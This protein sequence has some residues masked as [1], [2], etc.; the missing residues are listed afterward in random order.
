MSSED[1]SLSKNP[2]IAFFGNVKQ[3]EEYIKASRINVLTDSSF[4]NLDEK[5]NVEK[6]N[7]K[8]IVEK[9]T[10]TVV[11]DITNE[12]LNDYLQR[13]F[14]ITLSSD[15]SNTGI[16]QY[17]GLPKRC[18]KLEELK[19]D[20][21]SSNQPCQ[22][23]EFNLNQALMERLQM[24]EAKN[25]VCVQGNYHEKASAAVAEASED[26]LIKYLSHCYKRLVSEEA[27]LLR[28]NKDSLLAEKVLNLSKSC[29]RFIVSFT[30]TI[31]LQPDIFPTNNPHVQLFNIIM[32]LSADPDMNEFLCKLVE[33]HTDENDL[34]EIFRPLLDEIWERCVNLKLLHKDVSALLESI[35]FFSKYNSLTWILL[36]SP[37]WLPRFSSHLV[38]L[39]VAFS[40]QTLLGR[41]LQLSP[42]PNDVTTPSEHFL[43]PSRQSESQM[44]FITESLQRQT[45]FI[46][47]KLH[48][49]LYNIMKVPDAQHRVMYWIGLCLDCNKDR[50]KM[51]VDSSVVAPA[52]FFVNL[53]HV[54]LKFCQPFLVPNS[55]LL[56]KVDCRYGAIKTDHN[57]IRNKDTPIHCVGLSAA[58]PMAHKSDNIPSIETD[59][60][61]FK[62]TADIFFLTHQCY[63]LGFIKVYEEYHELMKQLQKTSNTIRDLGI[64]GG[65]DSAMEEIKNKFEFGMRLQLSMKAALCNSSL[66]DLSIQF[67]AASSFWLIQ[68]V[69]AGKDYLKMEQRELKAKY[70]T[71][72]VPP[73]LT[74]IPEFLAE[75]IGDTMRMMGYFNEETLER[76]ANLRYIM[77]FFA[78]FL[79]SSARIK[80]PHLRAK[81]AESLAVFLPKETEQHNSLFSYSFRKKAFLESSVVPK[82]L[83]KSLLQLFVDIEFTGHTMEF[84]QKFNYRH[85]MYG[86]LEYIWNIPSYHTEFKKLD[87]EGKIQYKRDM[88]F[89]SFPRFINLLINDSTYLLDEALQNLVLIKTLENEKA[90]KEWESLPTEERRVKEQNLQQYGY[91]AKN[92]NIMANETVHVLCYVTKD[93]SRPFASPC[94]IDGMAAFLNY[95]LVHLVGPKRRELK[96]S[97]FQKYNF[98]PRKLVVNILSIYLSLG[99]DDDFCRAIVKDGRS[100]STELFQASIELLERIEGRQEMVNEFRHF[101]TRLDKW[102]EQLKLEEQEMPE[103]PDE[104][105]DPISCV[106]M[107]DPVKLPSSGKIVCKS[108]ISKHLLSDEKDPFNRSPLRLDQVIPCYELREQIRAWMLENKID[109]KSFDRD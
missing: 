57:L 17:G 19:N 109:L 76:S 46:V 12:I 36:K 84:Y 47:T 27:S 85:Y 41:L 65:A 21:K 28:K 102:Y 72:E 35:I 30:G 2:F 59:A 11:N 103:P 39:G 51:Y 9:D 107:V 89:S 3:A 16:I 55:N 31:L 15:T 62:F 99:E 100:Y 83:P 87:E 78:V 68:Q 64:Q 94:M 52:G 88:V 79:G 67:C 26:L 38:T 56:L 93:I 49:F 91:F 50:A 14:L 29:R 86:I 42:I 23:S 74:I 77:E 43:E 40:T 96:V 95:F 90:S 69:L 61:K 58:N 48:E 97:D 45:D 53:T 80:N 32:Q 54:L 20:L 33:L 10:E 18:I 73:L 44:N 98:E 25:N 1:N 8:I 7:S 13:I 37:H 105:L 4:E 5:I 24:S 22:L 66:A 60:I 92:Y 82:I 104:F 108:T 6:N 75:N 101:I 81:L 106:L 63:K 71:E 70:L 34:S